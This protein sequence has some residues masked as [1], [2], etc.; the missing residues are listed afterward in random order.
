MK[1]IRSSELRRSSAAGL[2]VASQR[3]PLPPKIETRCR[4]YEGLLGDD[5][6]RATEGQ[7]HVD[8]KGSKSADASPEP[9][10]PT[11]ESIKAKNRRSRSMDDL[12]DDDRG[13]TD[14]LDNTQSMENLPSEEPLAEP[15]SP[16]KLMNNICLNRRFVEPAAEEPETPIQRAASPESYCEQPCENETITV[17]NTPGTTAA[18]K[19]EKP[20]EKTTPEDDVVSTASSLNSFASS[21]NDAAATSNKKTNTP[22]INKYV[23]KVKSL[24]KK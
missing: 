7:D 17:D 3:P 16:I 15:Q 21:T 20:Q 24:M 22:F 12:F 6:K 4:S 1:N 5:K 23:K 2:N 9:V 11:E 18:Q 19:A 10:K 8:T 13:L 14:F